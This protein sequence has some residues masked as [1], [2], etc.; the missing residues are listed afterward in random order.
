L[1]DFKII[2]Y[3]PYCQRINSKLSD[4]GIDSYWV[5]CTYEE[6]ENF[7]FPYLT[8]KQ[9]ELSKNL[10]E[11]GKGRVVR[12][13]S[14]LHCFLVSNDLKS[15]TPMAWFYPHSGHWG[16]YSPFIS[17]KDVEVKDFRNN[18]MNNKSLKF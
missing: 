10:W 16:A 7:I 13:G 8:C 15:I 3:W 14:N 5:E 1:I 18:L 11:K 12:V 2:L 6:A 9:I 17:V 4:L